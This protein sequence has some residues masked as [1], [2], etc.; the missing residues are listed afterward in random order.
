MHLAIFQPSTLQM[1]RLLEGQTLAPS[2]IAHQDSISGGLSSQSGAAFQP[3]ALPASMGKMAS[4]TTHL[5]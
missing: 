1:E 5:L 4:A 2:S 3:W